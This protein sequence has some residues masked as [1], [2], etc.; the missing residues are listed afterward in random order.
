[1]GLQGLSEGFGFTY[2]RCFTLPWQ[3][4]FVKPST[5]PRVP[6]EQGAGEWHDHPPLTHFEPSR[7]SDAPRAYCC[8]ARRLPRRRAVWETVADTRGEQ[9]R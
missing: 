1:M 9:P 6:F 4:R 3:H 8:A 2:Y 7:R 5:S